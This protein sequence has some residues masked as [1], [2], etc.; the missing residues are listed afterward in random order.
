MSEDPRRLVEEGVA[1]LALMTA[2]AGGILILYL[3]RVAG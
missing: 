3:E 1:W 2:V